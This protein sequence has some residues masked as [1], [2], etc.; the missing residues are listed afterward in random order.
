LRIF[1]KN[2]ASRVAVLGILLGAATACAPLGPQ[3]DAGS[4]AP[5]AKGWV[6]SAMIPTDASTDNLLI[7]NLGDRGN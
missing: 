5:A 4:G 1:W 3:A 7:S 2:N 6:D